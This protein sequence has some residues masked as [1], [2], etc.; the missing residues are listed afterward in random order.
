MNPPPRPAPGRILPALAL[1]TAAVLGY[2][3]LLPRIIAVQHWHHLTEVVIAVAL[4]GLSGAPVL[5]AVFAR[6]ARRHVGWLLPAAALATA[7]AI[8]LSL[9]WA[10]ALPLNMLALP[11]YW[12]QAGYL[13]LY[14]LCY[15]LPF[16]CGGLFIALVLMRWSATI[17]AC[18]AADLLGSAAGALLVLLWLDAGWSFVSLESALLLCCALALAAFVAAA[19]AGRMSLSIA[20][21]A[22]LGLVWLWHDGWLAVIPSDFKPLSVQL[23]ERD[24][25]VLEQRDSSQSRLTRVSTGA[26]HLAPGISLASALEAPLQQQL[27][28]DGE[29]AFPL[30]LEGGSPRQRELFFQVIGA[31]AYLVAPSSPQVLILPGN[32]SWNGWSAFWHG[33]V[34]ITLVEP[35]H[36]LATLLRRGRGNGAGYIP[37]SAGVE[38]VQPRR[39]LDSPGA[40]YD[41]IFAEVDSQAEGSSATRIQLLLTRQGLSALLQRLKPAGVLAFSGQ[42]MP[43]PRDSLRL[44]NSLVAVLRQRQLDPAQHLVLIRDWQNYLLLVSLEP[45]TAQRVAALQQWSRR[46]LF[47]LALMPG[48]DVEQRETFHQ[49]PD[50]RLS[51]SLRQLLGTDRAQF[52]AR[53]PFALSVTSDDRPFFY[54]F[55]RWDHWREVR[56]ALGRPW[57]LYVGWGYLLNLAALAGLAVLAALLLLAPLAAPALRSQLGGSRL[58]TAGYF[59]AIG[60]GFMFI[61]IT[62]IQKAT[63]LLASTTEAFA[64]VL[65]AMLLGAGAGSLLSGSRLLVRRRLQFA[66]ACIVVAALACP[67]LLDGFFDLSLTWT[68]VSREGILALLV[69]LTA[70]P[71]GVMLP[72]GIAA[73]RE[74]GDGA[75]AWCWAVCGF[76][77][78]CGALAAPLLAIEVGWTG[79]AGCAAALYLLAGLCHA[80]LRPKIKVT[81]QGGKRRIRHHER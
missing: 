51:E 23:G 65:V 66:V 4:L 64:L 24:A 1:L 76:C 28:V 39:M 60:L 67:R 42:L 45:F 75:V 71:M 22:S 9:V 7:A 40:D 37:D 46:W 5:V 62:L 80:K 52:V 11:W 10:Q 57:L 59:G 25:R 32:H 48:P 73:I 12:Q 20:A 70:L 55:F 54:H 49:G 26:Q 74:Q 56:Q 34:A 18:Y 21:L 30:L 68:D 79:L 36:A 78:V 72:Q 13:L 35:D 77:S 81:G 29:S 31:A 8:P 15:V 2:E 43:W 27:F 3:V 50:E 63:L 38:E 33:A 41:L 17:G 47:D 6:S 69:L 61:E 44:I 16:F 19:G 53:Y 14:G 58:A